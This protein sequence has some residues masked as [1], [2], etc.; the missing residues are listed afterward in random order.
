MLATTIYLFIKFATRVQVL[1]TV[2][3]FWDE[4][5]T[6]GKFGGGGLVL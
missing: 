5:K 4:R 1:E 6:K 2:Q 3:V